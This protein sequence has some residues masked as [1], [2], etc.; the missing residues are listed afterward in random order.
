M[1]EDERERER[2]WRMEGDGSMRGGGWWERG[3]SEGIM[4][5][6]YVMD[7]TNS[8]LL[9][10]VTPDSC[11]SSALLSQPTPPKHENL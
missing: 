4:E 6:K 11:V 1:R 5:S 3:K 7:L 9:N 2:K 8:D 10:Q